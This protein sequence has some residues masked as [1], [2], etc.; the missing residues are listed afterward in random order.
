MLEREGGK[1]KDRERKKDREKRWKK[2][3]DRNENNWIDA[4]RREN[5][6]Y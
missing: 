1:E 3:L 6:E 2:E 5:S 4:I